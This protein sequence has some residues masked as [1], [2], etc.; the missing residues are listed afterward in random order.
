MVFD[1]WGEMIFETED[2]NAF[3]DVTHK[4]ELVKQDVYVWKAEVTFITG[5][6]ENYFGHVTVIRSR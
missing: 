3:W 4:G 6:G 5:I 2:L 1:R